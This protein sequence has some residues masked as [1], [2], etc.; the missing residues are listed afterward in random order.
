MR[1]SRSASSHSAG[2]IQSSPAVARIALVEDQVDDLEHRLEALGELRAARHF[3]RHA[4]LGSVRFART[5]RCA[6]VGSAPGT[7]ARS[8]RREAAQQ[9]SVSATRASVASTG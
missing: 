2:R 8:R 4:R 1:A 9:R 7:R 5:M 3:E 6:I